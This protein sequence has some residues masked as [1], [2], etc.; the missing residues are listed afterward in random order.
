MLSLLSILFIINAIP[1]M[2]NDVASHDGCC[3]LNDKCCVTVFFVIYHSLLSFAM[4]SNTSHI[5]AENSC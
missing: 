3:S 4:V 5:L 1:L 2:E